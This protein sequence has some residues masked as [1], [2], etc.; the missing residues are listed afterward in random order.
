MKFTLFVFVAVV[1]VIHQ[2]SDA[3]NLGENRYAIYAKEISDYILQ[4]P[5]LKSLCEK[6][7]I[8]MTQSQLASFLATLKP[9][10]LH[11]VIRYFREHYSNEADDQLLRYVNSANGDTIRKLKNN[12]GK[13]R[14]LQKGLDTTDIEHLRKSLGN[15]LRRLFV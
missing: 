9:S 8:A 13:L 4:R 7:E 10:V 5:G 11:S 2:F 3:T 1:L 14:A 15:L 12:L 6:M